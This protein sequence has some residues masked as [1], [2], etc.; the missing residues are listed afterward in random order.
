MKQKATQAAARLRTRFALT[1]CTDHSCPIP[2]HDR[3]ARAP[4]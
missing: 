3:L 1:I 4:T 2:Q